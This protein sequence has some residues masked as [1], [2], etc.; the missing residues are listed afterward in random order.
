[1]SST[2]TLVVLVMIVVPFTI[3]M[4]KGKYGFA[5]LGF[6]VGIVWWVGVFRL[7][8]PGSPWARK[9]YGP[10]KIA[11]IVRRHGS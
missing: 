9:F 5:A 6:L 4:T 10:D 8:K 1:M 7:A 11:E 3:N 2:E